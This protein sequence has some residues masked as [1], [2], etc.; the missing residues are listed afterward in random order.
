V[1]SLTSTGTSPT[2]VYAFWATNDCTTNE[3]AWLANGGSSN[4]GLRVQGETFTN[5]VGGLAGDTFFYFNFM[6]SNTT[7]KAWG[8]M[9][10]SPSFRTLTLP[11]VN[12]STGAT[13]VSQYSATLNGNL[14][15]GLT[16]Y[17]YI[18]WW[19]NNASVTNVIDFGAARSQG[20]FSTN[21]T[22]LAW[23]TLYYY[24][25]FASNAAGTA[26]A[27]AASNFTTQTP[28][29]RYVTQTGGGTAPL[30]GSDWAHAYSN[31]Q[32]AVTAC[33][34]QVSEIYL[35]SGIYSNAS[36]LVVSNHPGLTIRGGYVG[37]GTP[38]ATGSV[39][40]IVTRNTANNIRIFFCTNSILALDSLTVSNGYAS[41]GSGL[42][43]I[44]STTTVANCTLVKN[45]SPAP[46]SGC[47]IYMSSGS[48]SI[49]NSS[50][51]KN[52]PTTVPGWTAGYG[53]AIYADNTPTVVLIDTLFDGNGISGYDY[54]SGGC[55]YIS[56]GNLQ[57]RNCRFLG[58]YLS[59]FYA[60]GILHLN[61]L[62]SL[63]ISNCVFS[64]NTV[65]INLGGGLIYL[66]GAGA[67]GMQ[68]SDCLMMS[69]TASLGQI[70]LAQSGGSALLKNCV[71]SGSTGPGIYQSGSPST[72]LTN[73]LISGFS[74][75]GV[76]LAAGRATICNSTIA[77]NLGCGLTNTTAGIAVTNLN[78]IYWGN[79]LGGSCGPVTSTYTC[80]QETRSGAGNQ[81]A[82][83]LFVAGYYLSA[84]G[85]AYQS[86]N[87]PCLDA[88]S[89]AAS[90][91]G[92]NNRSTRTDGAGDSGGVDLGYHY[93]AV[94]TTV[95]N[96]MVYVDVNLGSDANEGWTAGAGAVKTITR[97]LSKVLPR[98]TINVAVGTYSSA[99]PGEIFPLNVATLG[100]TIKGTNQT[101][102][103]FDALKKTRVMTVSPLLAVSLWLEG[104]TFANGSN[105]VAGSGLYA[106]S[107]R[108]TVTNCTFSRNSITN[109]ACSLAGGAIYAASPG[110]LT[111]VDSTIVSNGNFVF[112]T[113]TS[114][115]G[116][117]IY[118]LNIPVLIDRCVFYT[119]RVDGYDNARGG[120]IHLQGATC[121]ATIRNS[122]FRDNYARG[123]YAPSAIISVDTVGGF[124]VSNCVFAGN[125][126]EPYDH[127]QAG[128]GGVIG[129]IGTGVNGMQIVDSTFTNNAGM[130]TVN[131]RT[132]G[133]IC[134]LQNSGSLLVRNCVFGNS[135][136]GAGVFKVGNGTMNLEHC[137]I[138][139]QTNCGVISTNLNSVMTINQCTF[140]NNRG[141]GVS[142]WY[143]TI[144]VSNSI[145]WGN[146][147]G[148]ITNC[149][150]N[151]TCSQEA[152][153]GVGNTNI[154]PLF[155]DTNYFH[156]ASRG[157][158][159][160]SGFFTG[161]TWSASGTTNS[162][163][164]D[165]GDPS[166]TAWTLETQPNGRRLNLGAYAGTPVA[167]RTFLAEPGVFSSLRVHAYA[168]TNVGPDFAS[169]NGEILHSG[170]APNARAFFCY[171]TLDKGVTDTG[172]WDRV[173]DVGTR[174]QWELFTTNITGLGG[175][176]YYRAYVTNSAGEQSW[177]S[178]AIQLGSLAPPTVTNQG[179][180][181]VRRRSAELTG[182]VYN[183]DVIQPDCWF[184]Y[185][186]SGAGS[187][188]NVPLGQQSA[189]FAA[190]VNG[191][192]PGAL[193]NFKILASNSAGSVWSDVAS[194]TTLDAGARGWYVSQSGANADGTNWSTAITTLTNAMQI[195]EPNDSLYLAG[196]SYSLATQLTWNTSFLT[197]KGSF[198]ATN[199]ADQPGVNDISRWPTMLYRPE[200]APIKFRILSIT[201]VTNGTLEQVV[202]SGGNVGSDVGGT[203]YGAGI[204]IGNST[205]LL[206][207]G[208]QM[209]NNLCGGYYHTFWGAGLYASNS[210]GT[211]SNCL[212]SSNVVNR[213]YPSAGWG[214]GVGG[215]LYVL[216]GNWTIRDS[217]FRWN[218]AGT[219]YSDAGGL[220]IT[221][222]V[223]R[224]VNCLFADN[225]TLNNQV[226]SGLGSAIIVAGSTARLQ[227]ENCTVAG[228]GGNARGLRTL[229]G[230]S[231]ALTNCILWG[232]NGEVSGTASLVSCTVQDGTGAGSNGTI[233][234]NPRF[235]RGYYLADGSPCRDRGNM[236]VAAAGLSGY[237]AVANGLAD[238]DAV[239][240]GYHRPAGTD[241]TVNDLY[242]STNGSDSV[243]VT[244]A[245]AGHSLR[246]ITRALVLARSSSLIH[247]GAGTYTTNIGE[248]F[249]LTLSN[250]VSDIGIQGAGPTQ[251]IVR[252]A[253]LT[254]ILNFPAKGN[255]LFEGLTLSKGG[256]ALSTGIGLYLGN[257]GY[258]TVTNCTIA[259]NT[260]VPVNGGG[261][262]LSGGH[263]DL[264]D[265]TMVSNG[266]LTYIG[267]TAGNGGALYAVDAGVT[268]DNVR[269]DRNSLYGYDYT[270]G[271]IMYVARSTLKI[272]NSRAVGNFNA[273]YY[274]EGLMAL[275]SLRYLSISNMV[276]SNNVVTATAGDGY[277]LGL[278]GTGFN[279]LQISD[280]TFVSNNIN[281]ALE[282]GQIYV[283]LSGGSLSV[284]RSSLGRNPKSGIV[285]GGSGILGIT[286]SLIYAQT[287]YGV[288]VS[289]G[290][291]SIANSTIVS[292]K[293]L[294]VTN[295]AGT[296]SIKNSIVWDNGMGVANASVLYS[297][298]QGLAENLATHVISQDPQ[299]VGAI[300]QNYS[301]ARSSPCLDV[302]T[303]EDWMATGIDLDKNPR[304]FRGI[305]DLGAYELMYRADGGT[306]FTLH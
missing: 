121:F 186:V 83:P 297:D 280:S 147:A 44:A 259:E 152:Q 168:A 275:D 190:T 7:G 68:I 217:V 188:N 298:V 80:A 114:P 174:V 64:N 176:T 73:C 67:N 130:A 207:S 29:F 255:L 187:S 57:V 89:A 94:A 48:L 61:A 264:F 70:T 273:S 77:D 41:A 208:C 272:S 299:F 296:V 247:V 144:S 56:G 15:T 119:N 260:Y 97:A 167:S 38:G 234:E 36:Q 218:T 104:V 257:S 180:R 125:K 157:G 184:Y 87:S 268:L 148:G 42:Y 55:L 227:M 197:V 45:G 30:D 23:G 226:G 34:G 245:D 25:C 258:T 232:N 76:Q 92:M 172:L 288:R 154:N 27:G 10:G 93:P 21:V 266:W 26:W 205:N 177:S 98:G 95:S 66:G 214:E 17:V 151:Y 99:T 46:S 215:G 43:L 50:F 118:A 233:S 276:F 9:T 178:N 239:D 131:N 284:Q 256:G 12:N 2:T 112:A 75:H 196:G 286:N 265:T 165:L 237:T 220:A 86:V 278:L 270:A 124:V 161:G 85:L 159:Y 139:G 102:T 58:N 116:G 145:A 65:S 279:G 164:I 182:R 110:S 111:V 235:E 262:A 206:I 292:N 211:I 222:G 242:V 271:G 277:L 212:V 267:Y 53:G 243:G 173:V 181:S 14:T 3:A 150:V 137:L 293:L 290:T 128:F 294:G 229:S 33:V 198:A 105:L 140:A 199:N 122:Q 115:Q 120:S 107:C 141:Y 228:N 306:I 37:S 84:N 246:T 175:S 216:G 189:T 291:V 88:G 241:V 240:L 171:G 254:R 22:G 202:I 201:G 269:L 52:G 28:F 90:D 166:S 24:Q 274:T 263:L 49:T 169:F 109:I 183:T 63:S 231:A 160:E 162:P 250:M 253:G 210:Y 302:G 195:A 170:S 40:S 54:T 74:S 127:V 113:G 135:S 303:N 72:V 146:N 8:S 221:S 32:D 138:Y 19:T 204:Y 62:G 51:V 153:A 219:T 103:I 238:T 126:V 225:I 136:A 283:T 91:L 132:A 133:Q 82:D 289:A 78:S 96:M 60:S 200:L 249:P 16:A 1:G 209:V 281:P 191:L 79:T 305:V 11:V 300:T 248:V 252:G 163:L 287:N 81:V 59:A 251:T 100:I 18:Y 129:F 301:L 304:K 106:P 20:P 101:A 117:G 158:Q 71:L 223:V 194:F 6:A 134:M 230:G 193:Y 108:T 282:G 123:F 192:T 224:A 142:N 5:T 149:T 69:N 4:L 244:G 295:S 155:V 39:P 203:Y 143:A 236:T 213:W 13:A 47:G 31:V 285:M 35:K 156:L 261:I 185:W 179:A